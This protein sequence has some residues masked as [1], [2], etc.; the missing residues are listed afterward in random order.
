ML[1]SYLYK[2][3]TKIEK[4][5]EYSKKFVKDTEFIDAGLTF[6]ML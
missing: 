3:F 4:K 1:F 5:S 2:F 6:V